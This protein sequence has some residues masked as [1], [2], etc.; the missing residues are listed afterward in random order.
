MTKIW[1]K[2]TQEEIKNRV[3]NALN[4]NVNF[5]DHLILGVPASYLD[6]RVFNQDESF[7]SNAPFM[8][9]LSKT[10]TTLVATPWEVQ[11]L[12]SKELKPLSANY[13]TFVR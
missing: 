2:K 1:V 7:L 5:N 11:K 8:S 3:F 12:F 6:D 4:E 9:A 13:W 10:Q